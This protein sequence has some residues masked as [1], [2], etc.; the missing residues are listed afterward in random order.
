MHPRRRPRPRAP[1][2]SSPRDG[3]TTAGGQRESPRGSARGGHMRTLIISDLQLGSVTRSDLLRR[4]E[5]RA[6]L[7]EALDGIDRLV[8]LGDVLE[9][10]HGPLREAMEAAR[11][12]FEDLGRA[13][14]RAPLISA[15]HPPPALLE[16]WLPP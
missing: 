8:L 15:R 10:R 16:P 1:S 14:P 11:P 13:F 3:G 12:F 6:T 7:L 2:E 4:S 9:L 5:L